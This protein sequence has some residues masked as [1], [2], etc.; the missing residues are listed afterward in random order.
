MSGY[1]TVVTAAI[2][3]RE[4]IDGLEVVV[5]TPDYQKEELAYLKITSR[6][7]YEKIDGVT[8]WRGGIVEHSRSS[9]VPKQF[10]Q[11]TFQTR[12]NVPYKLMRS[13]S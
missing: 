11:L 8:G 1:Q 2:A 4:M 10:T 6:D 3:N 9:K 12:S 7:N 13:H 5:Q